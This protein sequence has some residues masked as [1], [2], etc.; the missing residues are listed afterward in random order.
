MAG[1]FGFAAETYEVSQ[2]IGERVLLPAVREA[3]SD[4]L[5]VA[6]GFSCREQI[7]Q[8]T[9]RVALHTAQVL[10]LALSLRDRG[11][12]TD[13][14][15]PE[16]GVVLRRRHAQRLALARAALLLGAGAAVALV[17]ARRLREHR[18]FSA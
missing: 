14:E 7:E 8:E 1:A 3:A 2:L 16:R 6:D 11:G 15:R 18:G 9:D 17:G 13:G 12:S 10:E 4:T 5:I